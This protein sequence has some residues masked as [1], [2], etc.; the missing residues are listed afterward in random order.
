MVISAKNRDS[1]DGRG[2]AAPIPLLKADWVVARLDVSKARVY[3]LA[4]EG[5]IPVVRLGRAVRFDAQQ[6]EAFIR[7]SGASFEHG[8]RKEEPLQ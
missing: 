6:I 3:A 7:N 1:A 2:L 4:R 8:W 5:V